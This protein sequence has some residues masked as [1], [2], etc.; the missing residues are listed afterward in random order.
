VT[1]VCLRIGLGLAGG[2]PCQQGLN[3]SSQ[4]PMCSWPHPTSDQPHH[5]GKGPRCAVLWQK[6]AHHHMDMEAGGT[7][8]C[9]NSAERAPSQKQ[10]LHLSCQCQCQGSKSGVALGLRT[11]QAEPEALVAVL[12]G[13]LL[14]RPASNWAASGPWTS[15]GE[16]AY[17]SDIGDELDSVDM[18]YVDEL[19][20]R[21]KS[22]DDA[23]QLPCCESGP[24]RRTAVDDAKQLPCW[25]SG[26]WR[27]T[28]VDGHELSMW[29]ASRN[30]CVTH[31]RTKWGLLK[32]MGCRSMLSTAPRSTGTLYACINLMAAMMV[33]RMCTR[34]L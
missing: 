3:V 6:A 13:Q 14:L 4:A 17:M 22:D 34:L 11:G 9:A 10:G 16:T 23:P 5:D 30:F 29:P 1:W 24:W 33:W 25:E 27:R 26:P 2:Q 7:S 19:D 20:D 28:A 12:P 8:N 31:H 21:H 15:W 32:T 18:D